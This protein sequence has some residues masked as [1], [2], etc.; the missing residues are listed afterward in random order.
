MGG[1]RKLGTIKSF[2]IWLFCSQCGDFTLPVS[3][4]TKMMSRSPPRSLMTLNGMTQHT[5]GM[6]N[7]KVPLP[8]F[9]LVQTNLFYLNSHHFLRRTLCSGHIYLCVIS[10]ASFYLPTFRFL[11]PSSEEPS[12]PQR[13]FIH[14]SLVPYRM[15]THF[16]GLDQGPVL[17]RAF[18]DH[19]NQKLSLLECL[20]LQ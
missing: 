12:C 16:Q 20:Y 13:P 18:C 2:Q 1:I 10:W 6:T 11:S 8:I 9:T 19:S 5:S 15:S 17:L 14:S 3:S 7:N 4:S